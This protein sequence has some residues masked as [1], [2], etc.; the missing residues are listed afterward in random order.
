MKK[1]T[2]KMKQEN[3]EKIIGIA[4]SPV[5]FEQILN[6]IKTHVNF[7]PEGFSIDPRNGNLII[8]CPK[9][10]SRPRPNQNICEC[11]VCEKDLPSLVLAKKLPSGNYAFVTE[12]P[13][14]F[15]NPDITTDNMYKEFGNLSGL[16]FLLWPSNEH[17]DIYDLS[18]ADN[19]VSFEILGEMEKNIIEFGK[20]PLIQIVK[21]TNSKK[22]FKQIHA[23]YHIVGLKIKS[24]EDGKKAIWTRPKA[25]H[26][27][28]K[29]LRKK[30]LSFPEYV[31]EIYISKFPKFKIHEYGEFTLAIHPFRRRP[32]EAIIYP[33]NPLV[34]TMSDLNLLQRTD[35]AKAISD[36]SYALSAL[37]PA[38]FME[39]DYSIVFHSNTSMYCEI[40]PAS[41][42]VGG[43]ERQR[44]YI[45]ESSPAHSLE[46]YKRFFEEFIENDSEDLFSIK[47]AKINNSLV[48]YI[49][50][51]IVK[52]VD[53]KYA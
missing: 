50:E 52:R 28:L 15:L 29:F 11:S 51:E 32:L 45:C 37:M 21:N 23:Q 13:F 19:A 40:F 24:N 44:E 47:R 22:N 12:N 25:D 20:Y 38:M 17:K 41:Q 34:R 2:P 3:L 14:S 18:Y 35:L 30:G 10:R 48:K 16:N 4:Q 7:R 26:E 33:S 27:D 49:R 39:K 9:R 42:K 1:L 53:K 46:L 6:H 31:A 8:Y 36:V 43:F 5:N